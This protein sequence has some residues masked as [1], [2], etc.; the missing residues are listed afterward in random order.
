MLTEAT[1]IRGRYFQRDVR[2]LRLS[3]LRGIDACSFS[4]LSSRV[5]FS[6][7][8]VSIRLFQIDIAS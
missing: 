1:E 7:L 2:K 5:K 6:G 3:D 4:F 8:E